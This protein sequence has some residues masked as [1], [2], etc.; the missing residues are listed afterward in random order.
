M[1]QQP[2]QQQQQPWTPSQKEH[3]SDSEESALEDWFTASQL[4]RAVFT[5]PDQGE[6]E[7]GLRGKKLKKDRQRIV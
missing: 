5:Q 2:Q 1:E 6:E 7:Q 3:R 4:G